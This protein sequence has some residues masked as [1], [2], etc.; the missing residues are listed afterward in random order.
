[1]WFKETWLPTFGKKWEVDRSKL[2]LGDVIGRG[3]YGIVHRGVYDC[4]DE[5]GDWVETAVA[6]KTIKGSLHAR[7]L[8]VLEKQSV[9]LCSDVK[10]VR[11]TFSFFTG[12][13]L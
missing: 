12:L 11:K 6:I 8:H 13:K 10:F 7:M 9:P 4:E 2:R 1:M 3:N 5:N